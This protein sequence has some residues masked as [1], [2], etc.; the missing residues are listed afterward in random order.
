VQQEDNPPK[1][2]S[3][4]SGY[5]TAVLADKGTFLLVGFVQPTSI[6]LPV[7]P[8]ESQAV[9]SAHHESESDSCI[10][11]AYD[12]LQKNHAVDCS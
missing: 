11:V 4:L 9:N 10:T 8:A 12:G 6:R 3:W 2:D 5:P 1:L 7:M